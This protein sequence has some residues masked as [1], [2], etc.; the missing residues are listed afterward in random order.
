MKL[1]V[2]N[3]INDTTVKEKRLNKL[4]IRINEIRDILNDICCTLAENDDTTERLLVSK[5]LDELI[6]EFMKLPEIK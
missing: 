5:Y 1:Y 3:I 4:N 6:L 2:E